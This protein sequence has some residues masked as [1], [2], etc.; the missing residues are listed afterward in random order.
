MTRDPHLV[1]ALLFH[2]E[3]KENDRMDSCP[4][5]PEY[6]PLEIGYHL[7]LLYE[8]GFIRAEAEVSKNGRV[9][10]VHPFSLTWSGHE[11][12]D[13]ARDDNIWNNTMKRVSTTTGA[14]SFS[15][16]QALLV[17]YAKQSFGL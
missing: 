5:I 8:A 17:G 6:T 9:I 16:L 3:G 11:F 15:V 13:A 7:V 12:L 14:V 1:R 10:K 4:S 2:F